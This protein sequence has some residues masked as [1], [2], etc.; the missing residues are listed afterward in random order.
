M[1]VLWGTSES[2]GV[3]PEEREAL[4]GLCLS[5]VETVA[6]AAA[7]VEAARGGSYDAIVAEFPMAEWTAEEWL[8]EVRRLNRSLPVIIRYPHG[9]FQEA[10]RLTKLGAYDFL[11]A[12]TE[13]ED[14]ARVV[15]RALSE[16]RAR[17]LALAGQSDPAPWKRLL[18]GESRPIRT[19]EGIIRMIAPRRAT[20]LITGETGTGKEVA[21]RAIHA[22]SG[23]GHLPMVAVNCNA[24]PATLLEA[25]LFGHVKGAFTGA[26]AQRVG[27]FELAH[28]STLFLD[29][30][31]DMPLDLQAKLLRVIQDREVQRLGSSDTLRLD[32]RIIVASNTDLAAGVREGSF[33]EDLFYRLNIV[34]LRMPP[35]RERVSDIPLLAH[36]FVEKVCRNEGIAPKRIAEAAVERLCAYTWPGNVRQLENAVEMAVAMSGEEEVLYPSD[37]PLPAPSE[38][39]PLAA[40]AAPSIRLPDDGLDFERTVSR[41]ERS[42]L[43]QALER[44]GGNKKQAAQ[45]LR[46]KRTTLSAK[47]KSLEAAAV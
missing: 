23:R 33:R 11:G 47:L 13:V 43:S 37:F 30:I 2:S 24:L 38:G 7:A 26:I 34:P 14:T 3:T 25:E 28:R 42:I 6:G 22:A 1:R 21:A 10:V 31:G 44:T 40:T 18:V 8:E 4:P 15:E 17:A 35:L 41:I 12:G 46:L 39:K 36:H 20:V 45:M 9:S 5:E 32:V 29:E 19:I 27:R 16:Q